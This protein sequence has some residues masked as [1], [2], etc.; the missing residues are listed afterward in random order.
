MY[1]FSILARASA[2]FYKIGLKHEQGRLWKLGTT[3][4][5]EIGTPVYSGLLQQ[6]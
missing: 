4:S 1:K 3:H 5:L 6:M 2:A